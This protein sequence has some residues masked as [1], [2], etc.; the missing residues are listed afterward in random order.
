MGRHYPPSR[1]TKLPSALA[2]QVTRAPR[3]AVLVAFT[4]GAALATLLSGRAGLSSSA[5][6]AAA[7]ASHYSSLA[8]TSAAAADACPAWTLTTLL[9]KQVQRDF[10]LRHFNAA[11]PA[12]GLAATKLQG[13][14]GEAEADKLDFRVYADGD[15][16]SRHIQGNGHWELHLLKNLARALGNVAEAKGLRPEEVTLLDIGGNV[17]VHT[18]YAQAA[19]FSTITFEPLPQNE[20]IIRSNL[21]LNDPEQDRATLFTK[22]LGS[23]PAVC[24]QYSVSSHNRGNGPCICVWVWVG[25]YVCVCMY[26]CLGVCVCLEVCVSI[27]PRTTI[28]T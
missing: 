13:P 23:E 28:L 17:G 12:P 5:H 2:L 8:A 22:G 15:A 26:V 11:A 27:D 6:P 7:A 9:Q 18:T 24:E 25:V 19:G 10:C 20:P 14:R 16:V 4:A 3:T 1:L 21:C